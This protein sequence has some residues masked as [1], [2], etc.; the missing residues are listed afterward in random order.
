MRTIIRATG[1]CVPNFS[2]L[3]CCAALSALIQAGWHIEPA[4]A[5]TKK[6]P[7]YLSTTVTKGDEVGRQIVFELKEALLG[8]NSFRLVDASSH[9]YIKLSMVSVKSGDSASAASIAYV[10]DNLNQPMQGV[11]ISSSVQV[12]GVSKV[13]AC[14]RTLLAGL[15]ESAEKLAKHS[16]NLHQTLQR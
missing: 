14:V 16:R 1:A 5:Q 6:L 3:L 2:K 10:Y 8:S 11:L 15:S 12:C 13:K 7:V 9:P 4:V